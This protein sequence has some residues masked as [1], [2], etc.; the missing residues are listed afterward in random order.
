MMDMYP[1]ASSFRI[2]LGKAKH[3]SNRC[4]KDSFKYSKERWNKIDKPPGFEVKDLVFL[5]TLNVNNIKGPKTFKYSFS[6]PFM[7]RALHGPNA[8]KLELTG[9]LMN[10][11]PTFFVSVVRSYSS[12][13]QDLFLL[14]YIIILEITPLEEGEE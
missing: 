7:I 12:S 9:G 11:H 3:H 5:S 1:T 6:G 10:T 8:V 2:I 13:N 4:M 14:R